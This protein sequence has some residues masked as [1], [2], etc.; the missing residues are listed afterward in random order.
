[1]LKI[2]GNKWV[3]LGLKRPLK[4]GFGDGYTTLSVRS[5]I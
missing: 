3:S 2:L 5:G 4:L 1:M